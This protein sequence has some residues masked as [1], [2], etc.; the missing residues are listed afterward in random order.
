MKFSEIE[1]SQW[2]ELKPYLDTCLLPVTGLTGLESPAEATQALE[3][4]RDIMDGIEIP[5]KGRVVTYPACHYT[6]EKEGHTVVEQL[7]ASLKRTGFRYIIVV[8]ARLTNL[9]PASADLVFAP[10]PTGEV[11]ST[12]QIGQAIRSMWTPAVQV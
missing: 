8:S 10:A 5:F 9:A 7:C 4:L 11:P 12:E 2:D 6:G 1:S 3:D